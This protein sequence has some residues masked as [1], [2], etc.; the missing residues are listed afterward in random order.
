MAVT[1]DVLE[2]EQAI[3]GSILLEPKILQEILTLLRP[4][5][6]SSEPARRCFECARRLFRSGVPVDAVT[7]RAQLG[8]EFSPYLQQVIEL[9]PTS[10]NWQIYADIVRE[11]SALRRIQGLALG[12]VDSSTLEDCRESIAALSQAVGSSRRADSWTARELVEDFMDTQGSEAGAEYI[13]FGFEELD[14]GTYTE[15]G[16]VLVIGGYPSDGKTALAL[17]MA[18]HMAQK[19]R[20]GFF[21]LETDKRKLRDR[22]MAQFMGISFDK[23]KQRKLEEEDWKVIADRC[24]EFA[25]RQ[26]RVIRAGGMTVTEIAAASQAW[27]FDVIFVDYV[28][29][30]PAEGARGGNRSEQMAEVS[31]ALHTFAQT[32]GTLVVELAQLARPEKQGGWREPGMHDLK[33]SGQFEQDADEILLLFRPNPKKDPEQEAHRV[34]RVAKN[35]EGRQG[36]WRLHFDGDRQSFAF[37][38]AD[39]R[40][41]QGMLV[42]IGRRARQKNRQEHQVSMTEIQEDG[43]LPF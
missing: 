16:D 20:V 41:I 17:Q 40:E 34:L 35:K 14:R 38:A 15:R 43:S 28:Q 9:T 5:D 8:A 1:A 27:G 19:Y 26:L 22:M 24:D 13:S 3:I 10:A 33:E 36:K 29:L 31:R 11:Q 39:S 2:A 25:G 7:I 6:F 42:D 32:T 21:S 30:I 23:I 4:E 12:I 18:S 37:A